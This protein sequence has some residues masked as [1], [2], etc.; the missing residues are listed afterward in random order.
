M[1]IYILYLCSPP[2][3]T[4]ALSEMKRS[5]FALEG[6]NPP[7]TCMDDF[8]LSICSIITSAHLYLKNKRT[9]MRRV[10]RLGSGNT[11]TRQ[12]WR[13]EVVARSCRNTAPTF[14][15][16]FPTMLSCNFNTS[17]NNYKNNVNLPNHLIVKKSSL[18]LWSFVYPECVSLFI[19]SDS[20]TVLSVNQN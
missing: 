10:R 5:T 19:L 7:K 15:S 2:R 8:I 17:N 4:F 6:R 1:Y 13:D 12:W 14:V 3:S 16:A 9:S 18:S 20:E 11:V